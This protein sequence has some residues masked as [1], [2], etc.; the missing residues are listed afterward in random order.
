MSNNSKNTHL[1]H[2]S[3]QRE[4]VFLLVVFDF[5]M[6][7]IETNSSFDHLAEY[8]RQVFNFRRSMCFLIYNARTFFFRISVEYYQMLKKMESYLMEQNETLL[9]NYTSHNAT[10]IA[11]KLYL[12]NLHT[13][14]EV[15]K[16]TT[17]L[18]LTIGA[19]MVTISSILMSF[20]NKTIDPQIR[21]ILLSYST[22]D[23]IQTL[24]LSLDTVMTICS[25]AYDRNNLNIVVT[26][27]VF[28]SL[29]HIMFL[30]IAEHQILVSDARWRSVSSF[31]GLTIVSWII[32]SC[33]GCTLIYAKS[34]VPHICVA[35]LIILIIILIVLAFISIVKKS[36]RRINNKKMYEKKYLD[37]CNFR[38]QIRKRFWKLKYFVIILSSYVICVVPW[39]TKEISLGTTYFAQDKHDKFLDDSFVL[40]VYTINFYFP[41]CIVM[42]LWYVHTKEKKRVKLLYMFAQRAKSSNEIDYH[43]MVNVKD[44][45]RGRKHLLMM[46]AKLHN[47]ETGV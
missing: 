34:R 23:F 25:T 2:W 12:C 32:S 40:M 5:K 15:G 21:G 44:G 27:S 47:C 3:A 31:S 38:S 9:T 14:Q 18:I 37:L 28:L 4:I 17:T 42:Y 22:S 16:F 24:V 43:S 35:T 19:V 6:L 1:S 41:S 33:I 8:E 7:R 13:N 11:E 29:F 45:D 46:R 39:I 10:T 26:I 30:L 36:Q 20:L